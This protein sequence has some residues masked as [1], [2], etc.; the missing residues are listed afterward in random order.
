MSSRAGDEL[1]ATV[2]TKV[3][4]MLTLPDAE[5]VADAM[6]AKPI[7]ERTLVREQKVPISISI[8]LIVVGV[9]LAVFVMQLLPERNDVV[10]DAEDVEE[11]SSDDEVIYE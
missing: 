1:R 11:D 3:V 8:A 10:V 9:V 2:C 5:A 6:A 7:V 4:A